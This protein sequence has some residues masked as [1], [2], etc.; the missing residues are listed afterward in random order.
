MRRAS[1][2]ASSKSCEP[3]V[4]QHAAEE[5][6][7]ASGALETGGKA[8][9]PAEC[10]LVGRG[11]HDELDRRIDADGVEDAPCDRVKECLGEFVVAASGDQ[12]LEPGTQRG[13]R[14]ALLETPAEQRAQAGQALVHEF[15]VEVESERRIPLGRVP[16][17]AFE[18]GAR[19][20]RQFAEAQDV[21]VVGG[22]DD[23]RTARVRG[24]GLAQ[25][26]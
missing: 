19:V 7:V 25:G 26:F 20:S 24:A 8:P 13:P 18:V 1:P 17:P 16:V 15:C 10:A 4:L 11:A 14:R 2:S 9:R 23:L 6:R 5:R 21:D 3:V 22:E 12:L